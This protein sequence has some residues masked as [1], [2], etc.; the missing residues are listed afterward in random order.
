M[1]T[2]KE[3][4]VLGKEKRPGELHFKEYVGLMAEKAGIGW[5]GMYAR[6]KRSNYAGLR[7]RR[8]GPK[9]IFVTPNA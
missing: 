6:I 8:I 3:R 4:T 1:K 7:L 9:T 2:K 5:G